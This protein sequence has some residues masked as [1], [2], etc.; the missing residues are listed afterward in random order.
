MNSKERSHMV[1]LQK[2]MDHL[3]EDHSPDRKGDPAYPPGELNALA[4]ATSVLSETDP[5]DLLLE[6]LSRQMREFGGRLGR[7]EAW[8]READAEWEEEDDAASG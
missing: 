4:W 1:A 3:R 6:R 2:R 7:A 5:T 8:I